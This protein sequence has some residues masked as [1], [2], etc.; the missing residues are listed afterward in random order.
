MKTFL[1]LFIFSLVGFGASGQTLENGSDTTQPVRTQLFI[2]NA[3]TPATADQNAYWGIKGAELYPEL[4]IKVFNRW[5]SI[6]FQQKGYATPW[7]GTIKEIGLP[8]GT[9]YYLITHQN[10]PKPLI[11][12]LTI[13]R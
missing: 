11:G 13:I 1:L 6:V 8:A 10:L 5:G 7:D 3:I 2:P 12:D 9:Y 4:D